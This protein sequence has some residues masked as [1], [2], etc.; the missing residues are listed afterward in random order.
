MSALHIVHGG[1][2]N[3]DKKLLERAAKS[4][5]K[6]RRWVVPKSVEPG[7]EVV[8]YVSPLGF[9]ATARVTSY[10]NLGLIG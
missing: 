1:I 6:V 9:F 3:G 5:L 7:D 10:S 2:E 8:I 4:K